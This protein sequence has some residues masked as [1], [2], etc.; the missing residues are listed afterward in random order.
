MC[1]TFCNRSIPCVFRTREQ[2][3]FVSLLQFSL[4]FNVPSH[5]SRRG[6]LQDDFRFVFFYC[7]NEYGFFFLLKLI[8]D[9]F[10]Y[11]QRKKQNFSKL[12]P[13]EMRLRKRVWND[14]TGRNS[15][16]RWLTIFKLRRGSD[17][18]VN[19]ALTV[20]LLLRYKLKIPTTFL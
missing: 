17:R 1:F 5:V 18:T 4:L 3:S 15:Y 9:I 14:G 20:T 19:H 16:W 13:M 10:T 6:P 8:C 7:I 12:I 2:S 11:V